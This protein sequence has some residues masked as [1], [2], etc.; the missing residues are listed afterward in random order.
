[1]NNEP[2]ILWVDDEIELLKPQILF[3]KEKGYNII[4]ASNGVDA[5]E[6]CKEEVLDIVF[7]D[8]QM[9]GM[10]GIETLTD[11]KAVQPNIPIVMITKSEE[12]NLMEEAIGSQISDYLIKPV[13]PNQVLL[14]L[15]KL[16]DNRRLISEKTTSSY[17]QEFQQIF[18]RISMGLNHE[19]WADVYRKLIYWELE[20]EKADNP[21]MKNILDMQKGEANKE[22]FK[23]MKI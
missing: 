21:D 8:E 13:K 19:E 2:T 3:L 9:P 5:I 22:F 14:T 23:F 6:K 18:S 12:E 7:L 11:I 10:S 15:K 17:Q 16:L 20:L 1:M 4:E